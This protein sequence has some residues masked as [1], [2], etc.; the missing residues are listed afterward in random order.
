[1]ENQT[2]NAIVQEAAVENTA[3]NAEIKKKRGRKPKNTIPQEAKAVDAIE[4]VDKATDD[5]PS[6]DIEKERPEVHSAESSRDDGDE[7]AYGDNA[8]AMQGD[9]ANETADTTGIEDK[10]ETVESDA[11]SNDTLGIAD[12]ADEAA[13]EDTARA[14]HTIDVAEAMRRIMLFTEE[15]KAEAEIEKVDE[16]DAPKANDGEGNIT[17]LSNENLFEEEKTAHED[18]ESLNT[19]GEDVKE[20]DLTDNG[21]TEADLI[22]NAGDGAEPTECEALAND[23]ASDEAKSDDTANKDVADAIAKE[24]VNADDTTD[25]ENTEDG[26]EYDDFGIEDEFGSIPDSFYEDDIPY[27]DDDNSSISALL[28]DDDDERIT[29]DFEKRTSISFSEIKEQMKRLK[30]EATELHTGETEE[31]SQEEST[32]ESEETADAEEVEEAVEEIPEITESPEEEMPTEEIPEEEPQ[33]SEKKS[34][35]RDINKSETVE[36]DL[37]EGRGEHIITIDR[38]RVKDKEIPEG[39]LID[40]VFEAVELFTF[41]VLII[42]L[43]LSFVFRHTTVSGPSMLPTFNDG[44]RLIIS[45]LFY[46]PKR[47]DVVVFDDRTN[48][49]YDDMPIIK[50]IIG[51]EGD[52]VKIEDGIIMVKENGEDEFKIVNYVEDME[53]P[54]RDMEEVT[55]GKGEMFVMGDNVNNSLD[56][57]DRNE[58][59][60]TRNVGNIKTDSILGKVLLRFYV[61]ETVFSE[62]T[63]EWVTKGRIVFD[64]KFTLE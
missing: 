21:A 19:E 13:Q 22:G 35:I 34:Y 15:M 58:N 44:D 16:T 61:V 33:I 28:Y 26:E 64:T 37:T 47:G 45:N 18:D 52:V 17:S 53:I 20:A 29:S 10:A 6:M 25:I 41:A 11:N 54:Y 49:A 48:E 57:T 51:L 43:L 60:P 14:E 63:Q 24:T 30:D 42:M 12:N 3:P 59:D 55:V 50:R 32:T 7:G 39:R 5:E 23:N 31:V 1:M 46:E 2:D 40:T 56:S 4:V 38:A 36:E 27:S 8:E 9:E 62:E